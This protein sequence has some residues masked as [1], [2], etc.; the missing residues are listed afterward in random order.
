MTY[1]EHYILVMKKLRHYFKTILLVGLILACMLL[2]KRR[3][4]IALEARYL[5]GKTKQNMDGS[6]RDKKK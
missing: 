5:E 2:K 3:H 6:G 4:R 1:S